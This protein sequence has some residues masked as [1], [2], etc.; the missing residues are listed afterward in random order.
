MLAALLLTLAAVSLAESI[1][2]DFTLIGVGAHLDTDPGLAQVLGPVPTLAECAAACAR[3]PHCESLTFTPAPRCVLYHVR[4]CQAGGL[5]Q[6]DQGGM[7]LEKT[8]AVSI[9]P[10]RI[11]LQDSACCNVTVPFTH[12]I[13]TFVL[14]RTFISAFLFTHIFVTSIVIG[15]FISALS[16]RVPRLRALRKRHRGHQYD[17]ARRQP[18]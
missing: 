11:L 18:H 4:A 9:A 6:S 3:D 15:D 10:D 1:P 5:V 2:A 14:S 16:H 12:L 7:I 8:A 17:R 13:S